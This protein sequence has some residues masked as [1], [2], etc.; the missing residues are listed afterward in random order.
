[1]P[2]PEEREYLNMALATALEGINEHELLFVLSGI[3]RNGKGLIKDLTLEALDQD[4]YC[5]APAAEL[6]TG[7]RPNSNQASPDLVDLHGATGVFLSE[8]NPNQAIKTSTIKPMIGNDSTRL[9]Q[10]YGNQGTVKPTYSTFLLCNTIP[11]LDNDEENLWQKFA[12]LTF[13]AR[14]LVNPDPNDPLQHPV[15]ST[16]KRQIPELAPHWMLYLLDQYKIYAGRNYTLPPQ[17]QRMKQC[18]VQYQ[19]TTNFLREFAEDCLEFG[20]PQTD[21][22]LVKTVYEEFESW[23]EEQSR[24]VNPF[25][26]W[27][28]FSKQLGQIDSSR[29]RHGRK[30]PPG[31]H[32]T[33]PAAACFFGLKLK[34]T[35]DEVKGKSQSAERPVDDPVR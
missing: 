5:K 26:G 35:H 10:N 2:Y 15:D 8:P 3:G 21:I 24:G 31:A 32:R 1:M 20:D 14:F 23:W 19:K 18:L 25:K 17:T 29:F 34:T 11:K 33:A 12:I 28:T 6:L 4:V 30:R 9:R 27:E 22:V 16:L 7:G 13:P